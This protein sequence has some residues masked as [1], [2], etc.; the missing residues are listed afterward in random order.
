[1][2]VVIIEDEVLAQKY[3]V[4]LISNNYPK[5][6]ILATLN[7]V[8]LSI[9]WLS[10]NAIDL[11]FM[12]VNLSDGDCS[13]ILDSVKIQSP[14]IF[15]TALI[16]IDYLLSGLDKTYLLNKPIKERELKNIVNSILGKYHM[17]NIN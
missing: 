16:N 4:D 1:M 15:T 9:D 10:N 3:L 8:D 17:K 6:E 7:S 12:D 11:I 5:F 2:R 13:R 14:I